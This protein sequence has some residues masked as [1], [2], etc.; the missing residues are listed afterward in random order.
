MIINQPIH[1]IVSFEIIYFIIEIYPVKEFT[2][3]KR[4]MM[5]N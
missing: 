5:V 2:T 3:V 4:N 1:D